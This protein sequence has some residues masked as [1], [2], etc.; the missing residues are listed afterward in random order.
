MAIDKFRSYLV[1]AKIIVYTDHAALKYLLT[2]KD[3][4]PRLITWIL[5]LQEFDLEIKDKNGIENSVA[6]HLSRMYFKN[7]QESPI[8]SRTTCSTGLTRLTLGMQIL[9]I[10]WFQGMYHQEQTRRSL[11]KKVVHIYGMSHT[12]SEYALMAYSGDV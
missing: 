8:H 4:K 2:K 10:L 5:L 1:G 7:P 3:A 11:F 9:L 12:S 6:N